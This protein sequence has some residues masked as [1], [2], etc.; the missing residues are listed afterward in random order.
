MEF[1]KRC[2]EISSDE[3]VALVE[4]G[5]LELKK[6]YYASSTTEKWNNI[7]QERQSRLEYAARLKIP[8]LIELEPH[9]GRCAIVGAAPSIKNHIEE[10]K[11]IKNEELGL[12]ISLNGAHSFLVSSDIPPNIHILFEIDVDSPEISCGSPAHRSV[13]YY[14]C[15]HCSQRLFMRLRNYHRVLWHCFDEP[16]DYQALVAH[17]FPNEFM[18]G[19][20]FV[21]FFR[22]LNIATILGY[23][24]FEMYGCDCSFEGELSHFEGYHT[25]DKETILTV[26][27]GTEEKYRIF[28]TKPSL[29]FL[30]SEFIRY[31]DTNQRGL[32]I[33]VHGDSL[34]RHLHMM[35]FPEQYQLKGE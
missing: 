31:C 25:K 35:E 20:G 32:S 18:V 15:S 16:P 28:K 5:S 30:A 14:I 23:R 6:M 9:K 24:T 34:M 7:L 13:Y 8:H 4:S 26:A 3:T 2:A 19:G 21:T 1:E 17:L 29:S 12:V 10:I 22:A 33:R 11:A 27:A